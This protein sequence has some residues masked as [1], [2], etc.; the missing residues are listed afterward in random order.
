M[1]RQNRIFVIIIAVVIYKAIN[2]I[3]GP[4]LLQKKKADLFMFLHLL[5]LQHFVFCF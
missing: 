3:I 5:F 2:L 4:Y 1:K